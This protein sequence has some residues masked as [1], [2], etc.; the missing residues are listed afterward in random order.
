MDKLQ[1]GVREV[2]E[3]LASGNSEKAIDLV[4]AFKL[5]KTITRFTL[6]R[7]LVSIGQASDDAI[8]TR[9]A[10][11]AFERIASKAPVDP[12]LYYDIANGY[13]VLYDIVVQEDRTRVFDTLDDVQRALKYFEKAR[14]IDP[15]AETN[16]GN[17]YDSLGRPVE[18]LDRYD[19]ALNLDPRFGMAL[20]N[21]AYA[22]ETLAPATEY[23]GAYLVM[24]HHLYQE[25]F[26]NEDSIVSVGGSEALEFFLGRDNAIAAHFRSVGQPEALTTKL[27]HDSHDLTELSAFERFYVETCLSA[28]LYLNVHLTDR[29]ATASIGDRYI[30]R[31][32][33]RLDQGS[34]MTYVSDIAFRL[35]EINESF[36]TA[37][38]LYVR[39]QFVEDVTS[40]ISEQTTLINTLDYS[41]SN[42]YVGLLKGAYKEAFSAL[43]KVAMLLNHYLDLGHPEN[44]VYYGNVWFDPGSDPA[45]HPPVSQNIQAEGWRL[46]GL[47]L[48]C[49]QLRGS[50]YSHLRNALTHRYVRVYRGNPGPKGTY[51]FE[52]LSDLTA[53]VLHQVKCAIMYLSIFI[54]TKERGKR[55]PYGL[56]APMPMNSNQHLDLW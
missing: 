51:L 8:I 10:L 55:T 3:L 16:M 23:S 11:D 4:L 45:S 36:A 29:R 24:A 25:A 49:T 31:I 21:K 13:Q 35:N 22:L 7:T 33:T 34:E 12:L 48:L 30:P 26:A 19:A 53:D 28:D 44:S 17:L 18:A 56:T 50:K 9:C 43:D 20:G 40:R 54:D 1:N 37:R 5:D 27:T 38:M 14:G 15:R 32:V 39:S 46:F 47:F 6:I 42:L 52:D 41:A 2:A